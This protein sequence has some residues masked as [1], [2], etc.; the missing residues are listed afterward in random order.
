MNKKIKV[1]IIGATGYTGQ[2]LVQLLSHHPNVK[3]MLLGSGSK[4]GKSLAEI[5]PFF[6]NQKELPK[7]TSFTESDLADLDCL[8]TATPNGF[9][10]KIA[11]TA[12]EKKVKIIDL[13]AD[14]RLTDTK[15]YDEWYAPL[16]AAPERVLSQAVYGL[17]EFN[18]EK[19]KDAQVLANPGCY[20]T[21]SAL[22]M[23]PLFKENLVDPSFC[24]IDA[25]SG[26]TGAGKKAE[27]ALLFAEINE[28][29]S[30]YK[31][32]KHRHTPEIEQ[33]IKLFGDKETFV[34][35]TPHLLPIKRGI[36]A[37]VYLKPNKKLKLAKIE[38]CFE[39]YYE[40]EP[41]V[42][43]VSESPSTKHVY[44]SNCC[45]INACLDERSGLIVITSVIDNLMKGAAGQA[46]QNFN[47][48]FALDEE[49]GLKNIGIVP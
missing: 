36:L 28:S 30:A 12:I 41:F 8:F 19:I 48:M 37:T 11:E 7:L 20:P 39:T 13:A 35:F 47:L 43:Y 34:R 21:A 2:C 5:N 4:A 25:K 22:A 27:E 17:P 44:G 26:T 3:I 33:S 42:N 38:S 23:L 40:H 9:A 45:H 49:S 14:F 10:V 18:R 16:K 29:F 31:V 24:I 15:V 32:N 6:I 1:G 46:V